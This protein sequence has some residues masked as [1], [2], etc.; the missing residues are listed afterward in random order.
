MPIRICPTCGKEFT[1]PLGAPSVESTCPECA[2]HEAHEAVALPR[3]IRLIRT[4]N[5][6]GAAFTILWALFIGWALLREGATH[7]SLFL[8]WLVVLL[9]TAPVWVSSGLMWAAS[10]YLSRRRN[11]ARKVT[12]ALAALALVAVVVFLSRFMYFVATGRI[13]LTGEDVYEIFPLA[14]AAYNAWIIWYLSRPATRSLFVPA[15]QG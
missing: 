13:P 11:W 9:F 6:I 3:A 14:F 10:K 12:M 7:R 4:L 1:R 8:E 15:P 5:S 2:R